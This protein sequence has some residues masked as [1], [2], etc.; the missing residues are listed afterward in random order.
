M[1]VERGSGGGVAVVVNEEIGTIGAG[2]GDAFY[3]FERVGHV[4][5]EVIVTRH[6]DHDGPFFLR[7]WEFSFRLWASLSAEIFNQDD[8]SGRGK[9]VCGDFAIAADSETV[10]E[11]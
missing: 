1:G 3:L 5:G 6:V 4:D 10:D 11:T 9:A 7:H 8:I 2:I